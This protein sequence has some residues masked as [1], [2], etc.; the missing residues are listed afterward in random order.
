MGTGMIHS[1]F[2]VIAQLLDCRSFQLAE[3]GKQ[4]VLFVMEE[5]TDRIHQPNEDFLETLGVAC[6]DICRLHVLRSTSDVRQRI[7]DGLLGR[8]GPIQLQWFLHGLS[9]SGVDRPAN[10]IFISG[11]GSHELE[12]KIGTDRG[13]RFLVEQIQDGYQLPPGIRQRLERC[14]K[15]G[16]E[17]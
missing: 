13:V 12:G 6:V 4:D 16:H 11:A 5:V 3:C 10:D 7:P 2:D 17:Q 1:L 8:F 14:G 9:Q 15:S